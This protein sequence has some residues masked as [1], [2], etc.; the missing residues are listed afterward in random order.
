MPYLQ[1]IG[2]HSTGVAGWETSALSPQARQD[3]SVTDSPQN[4]A[5]S[6]GDRLTMVLAALSLLATAGITVGFV[7]GWL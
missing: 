2:S 6:S 1:P 7:I 4:R 5:P 3:I